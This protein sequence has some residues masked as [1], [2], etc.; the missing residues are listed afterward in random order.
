MISSEPWLDGPLEGVPPLLQPLLF[1]FAQVRNDL[2]QYT[3]NVKEDDVWR[4]VGTI[5]ALGFQLRHM[6]GSAE[7]L[8]TYLFGEQLSPEQLH[9]LSRE[10]VPGATRAELLES[11]DA[12]LQRIEE[13]LRELDPGSLY[14][15][16]FVGRQ[17][18]PTTVIGLLVHIAEHTQ[19]HLGQA[20][21]TAKLLSDS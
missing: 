16:R 4:P 14:E 20:I 9:H 17:R 11:V 7:R 15:P 13:R 18:K 12:T 5:P 21:T 3:V 19:R 2:A 8:T 1:S 6:A 10:H